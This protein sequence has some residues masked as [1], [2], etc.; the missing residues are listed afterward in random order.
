MHHSQQCSLQSDREADQQRQSQR[1]YWQLKGIIFF[2]L[3]KQTYF[4]LAQSQGRGVHYN[5]PGT[6]YPLSC[7]L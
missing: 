5:F 3:S 2:S 4:N 7:S 1:H 6:L